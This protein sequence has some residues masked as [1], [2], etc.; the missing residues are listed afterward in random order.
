MAGNGKIEA[1]AILA[2]PVA[3]EV[4]SSR[5]FSNKPAFPQ[6]KLCDPHDDDLGYV[7]RHS[8]ES[9]IRAYAQWL[10]ERPATI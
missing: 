2:Q 8:L 6:Y 1:V 9:G 4:S 10:A 3:G 5:L 7:P